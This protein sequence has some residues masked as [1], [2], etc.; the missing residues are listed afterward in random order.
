ML[1]SALFSPVSAADTKYL[2]NVDF[3]NQSPGK[4]KSYGGVDMVPLDAE[5]NIVEVDGNKVLEYRRENNDGNTAAYT[6]ILGGSKKFADV[7]CIQYDIMIPEYLSSAGSWQFATSRQTP[8]GTGVQF[9][10]SGSLDLTNG[11]LTS[12][13]GRTVAVLDAGQWYTV[14]VVFHED[15]SFYDLYVDGVLLVDAASYSIN[16]SAHY[17]ERLR[18]GQAASAGKC[19]VYVD[20]IRVYNAAVPENIVEPDIGILPNAALS[21]DESTAEFTL[22][23]WTRD[24]DVNTIIVS[25]LGSVCIVL[26]G[27]L[28][29]FILKRGRSAS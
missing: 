19:V 17:P 20:N 4:A 2:A 18:I 13:G 23:V 8:S 21:D 5:L 16:T 7:H 11:T 27:I 3:E 24:Y 15:K 1:T 12:D 28:A 22:P 14:A 26:V 25:S 10:A 6:D 29:I 9:Q